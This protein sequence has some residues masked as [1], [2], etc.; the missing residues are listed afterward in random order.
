MDPN[1][2][3]GG[4]GDR[5]ILRPVPG[6]RRPTAGPAA[7]GDPFRS[8]MPPPQDSRREP[9]EERLDSV[10]ATAGL[11]PLV[12][13]ASPLLLLAVRLRGTLQHPSPENL[14][15]E[16]V[17]L[18]RRFDEDVRRAGLPPEVA[19]PARYAL[20]TFVDESVLGTPWG[21]Q[22]AWA[23]QSLLVTFHKEAWGGEKFFQIVE[24]AQQS[25]DRDRELLRLLYVCIALGFEGKFRAEERGRD[26][27]QEVQDQLAR[28]L[29]DRDQGSA[30]VD[31]SPHWRGVQDRRHKLVRYV[32]F[33]II[34]SVAGLLVLGAFAYLH[35]SLGSAA[36]P[37]Q[38]RLARI[39]VEPAAAA[40]PAVPLVR[41]GPSL[42]QL[43]APEEQAG[44]LEV[45]EDASGTT[46]VLAGDKWFPSGSASID[47]SRLP[48]LERI[49]SALAEAKGPIEVVGHT[50]DVP[51]RSFRFKDNYDLSRQRAVAVQ[52]LLLTGDSPYCCQ[53][54]GAGPDEPRHQPPSDPANRALNRRVEIRVLG[55]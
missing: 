6:G 33:W 12:D 41:T 22:S 20:C 48:I 18:M 2:P 28:M 7:G 31:L 26:R 21:S 4:G 32:P 49:T 17:Y 24:R 23:N 53:T 1:D 37:I 27:L 19:V 38:G 55:G 30:E 54:R 9:E 5:T 40:V 34:A 14:Y 10:A 39:G 43:L 45:L 44:E 52:T 15:R 36:A 25:G 3:D 16:A 13:A 29:R 11:G 50:D 47:G 35:M 8:A 42:K 46:I 51:L